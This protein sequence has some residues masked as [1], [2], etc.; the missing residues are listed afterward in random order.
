M[1]LKVIA[2]LLL[3][4]E[5]RGGAQFLPFLV[6][7]LDLSFMACLKLVSQKMS[8][9]K[10]VASKHNNQLVNSPAGLGRLNFARSSL[11]LP[12]HNK[13]VT[14]TKGNLCSLMY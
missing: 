7:A 12:P 6:L 9:D 3:D 2:D 10:I 8:V 5:T 4:L 14:C 13:S 11:R 1:K